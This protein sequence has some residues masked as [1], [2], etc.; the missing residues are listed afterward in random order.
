MTRKARDK[1]ARGLREAIV[2]VH[3][4]ERVV[5]LHAPDDIVVHPSSGNVFDDLN[6]PRPSDAEIEARR[7]INRKADRGGKP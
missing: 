6:V 1:I 4:E 7:A 2:V 5:H 3:G